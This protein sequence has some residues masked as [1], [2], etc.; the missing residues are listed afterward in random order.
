M[1]D[2]IRK[3]VGKVKAALKTREIEIS[4]IGLLFN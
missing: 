4:Q 2:A 1:K 3:V